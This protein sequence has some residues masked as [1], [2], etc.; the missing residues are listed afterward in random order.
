M[1]KRSHIVELMEGVCRELP[2][3]F[4]E[5]K[6]GL[7]AG[8][9]PVVRKLDMVSREEFDIQKQVLAKLHERLDRLERRLDAFLESDSESGSDT[10]SGSSSKDERN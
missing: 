2:E 10:S 3:V 9:E 1:E 4:S 6:R 8:V 5:V 7:K